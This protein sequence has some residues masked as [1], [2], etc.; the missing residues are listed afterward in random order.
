MITF[1]CPFRCAG[2]GR[3]DFASININQ[4]Y[5]F[6]RLRTEKSDRPTCCRIPKQG[7]RDSVVGHV[8]L[9]SNLVVAMPHHDFETRIVME[10]DHAQSNCIFC[11]LL[12]SKIRFAA[13]EVHRSPGWPASPTALPK[14]GVL[15]LEGPQD[16]AL[17]AVNLGQ[18]VEY[19]CISVQLCPPVPVGANA[20]LL[21]QGA[22]AWPP[23]SMKT[24]KKTN[25]P[26]S[27]KN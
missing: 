4:N 27:S 15:L 8:T 25:P 24:F 11:I 23:A 18:R 16:R 1:L 9:S 2:A 13:S 21:A 26:S 19:L 3:S 14:Q 22:K 10:S 17:W 6:T 12:Q 5:V 20:A 7:L